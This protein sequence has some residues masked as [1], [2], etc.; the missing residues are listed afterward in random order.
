MPSMDIGFDLH[1]LAARQHG[2]FTSD[3]ARLLGISWRRLEGQVRR[4]ELRRIGPRVLQ[5]AGAPDTPA[6][7]TM[8]AVLD[9]GPG[10]VLAFDASLAWWGVSGFDATPV[11]VLL[12][13][14]TRRRG[15]PLAVLHETRRIPEHH[16]VVLDHIPVTTPTRTVFDL[17]ALGAH[18]LRLGRAV[19]NL[20]A[21]RLT[22]GSRLHAMLAELGGRGRPGIA[23]MRE[24]LAERGP[25]YR[26][27]ESNL[28]RRFHRLVAEDGQEPLERQVTF[29]GEGWSARVDALDRDAHLVAEVDSD[30]YHSAL[31]DRQ[32]DARR[33]EHLRGAGLE[34]IRFGEDEIFH[35]GREAMARLW[36]A[37]QQGRLRHGAPILLR[38][39]AS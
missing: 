23:R 29:H 22:D 32:A 27:P 28:E 39:L 19:D 5:V 6:S 35:H 2:A 36:E 26:P 11:H 16:V 14:H 15:E 20:W 21:R 8:A 17:A 3:Q 30:R 34:V 24:T 7:R 25:D 10:A 38:R 18:P 13:R 31:T 37:R 12:P 33:A 1:E 9:A 4:G